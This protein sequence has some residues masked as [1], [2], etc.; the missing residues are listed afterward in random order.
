MKAAGA[1]NHSTGENK[2]DVRGK[3]IFFF[4]I[5]G[6]LFFGW[7]VFPALL[8]EAFDQPIQFSHAIHTGDNVALACSDCH[9]FDKDGRFLGIP[10][11]AECTR[12]HSRPMG[13][14]KEEE[15]LVRDYIIP[16]KVIP[17]VRY[18]RQ[19]ENVYFSH[20]T[21][22]EIAKIDCQSCHFGHGYTDKLSPGQFS[23]IS[24]YSL[25]VFGRTL[26][27]IPATRSLGMR[28]EDCAEC[29]RKRGVEDSC[30]DCHK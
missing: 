9:S 24:H 8:Y 12:C 25:D 26:F 27:N 16:R 2:D 17:W 21:H 4:G 15:K 6:A 10:S 5:V 7:V 13:I 28:M 18:L 29:H 30:M 22:V 19:P 14:S 1:V 3:S 20:A 11:S 23:R